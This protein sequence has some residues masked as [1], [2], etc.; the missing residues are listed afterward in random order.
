MLGVTVL[1]K[2]NMESGF[3]CK[4]LEGLER[5]WSWKR[6][7]MIGN[8]IARETQKTNKEWNDVRE[9]IRERAEV[10]REVGAASEGDGANIEIGWRE[11]TPEVWMREK[12]KPMGEEG[13]VAELT[14][15]KSKKKGSTKGSSKEDNLFRE[16]N[17]E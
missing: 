3:G 17:N 12:R 14:P 10:C 15:T 16:A 1:V 2:D 9:K 11:N 5:V 4:L 8:K 7:A 13:Q 6:I